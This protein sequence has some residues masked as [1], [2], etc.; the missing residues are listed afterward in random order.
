M[1]S[2]IRNISIRLRFNI[3]IAIVVAFITAMVLY[4]IITLSNIKHY[5]TY[6]QNIAELKSN[7]LNT[8]IFEQNFISGYNSDPGF[9]ST[10]ENKYL[11]KHEES[12]KKFNEYLELLKNDKLTKTLKLTEN[13]ERITQVDIVYNDLFKEIVQKIIQRGSVNSG[14]I[15]NM[16]NVSEQTLKQS[17]N[18]GQSNIIFELKQNSDNYLFS[19][20]SNH[21]KSFI[22]NF[23]KL[24]N[25]SLNSGNTN[26]DTAII[27][28]DIIVNDNTLIK[29]LNDYKQYF[30]SLVDIDKELGFTLNEGLYG[31]LRT[32]SQNI[33]PELEQLFLAINNNKSFVFVAVYNSIYIISLI[34]LLL[35]VFIILQFSFSIKKPIN[36]LQ[37]KLIPLSKG[38]IPDTVYETTGKDEMSSINN[39]INE[40][41]A[42][43]RQTTQFAITLGKGIFNTEF[44]PLSADDKLGNS[45]LEM[46]QNLNQAKID[47]EKR[48]KEDDMRKWANEGLAT[49]NDILRQSTG[50][51]QKLSDIVIRKLV[52]FLNANQAGLFIFNNSDPHDAHFDL[53]SS[54]AFGHEKK[55]H[56]KIYPGEGLVGTAAVEKETVYMTDIPQ[57]YITITSGLGGAAPRS[58]LI[59]PMKVE[60][61]V[62]GVIEIASFNEFRSY[63]I[64]FVEKVSENIAAS[65]SIA[66]INSRT[67][68]LLEQ[69]QLQAEQMAAQEQEMRRNFEE[70]QLAQEDSAR[71]E[72]EMTSIL[73]AI[74]DS[75]L[76]IE[77][78]T[79]G[80][81]TS[82]NRNL[83]DLLAIPESQIVDTLHQS[84]INPED[85]NEYLRFWLTVKEGQHVQR[86]EHILVGEKEY[87]LSVIY[88][89]ILDDTGNVVKI[90]S[91]ATDFSESKK[92]E[93]ELKKQT[94]IMSMQE[95]RMRQNLEVLHSTQD[96][97]AKKQ[98]QLEEI[99]IKSTANER[100][101]KK[102]VEKSKEQENEL[103]EK[104][105]DL[106]KLKEE[107]EEQK[108]ISGAATEY[109]FQDPEIGIKLETIEHTSIIAT[110]NLDGTLDN[111]NHNFALTF[112]YKIEEIKGKH[113]RMFI[114][115]DKKKSKDYISFWESLRKGETISGEFIRINSK[116]EDLF[117]KGKYSPVKDKE[118]NLIKI[119]E[120]LENVSKFKMLKF[121][122]TEINNFLEKSNSLLYFDEKG[123][124]LEANGV[125]AESLDYQI[126]EIIGK[127][128]K[129]FVTE[130][131]SDSIEYLH[132]WRDLSR[133]E[134]IKGV[135]EIIGKN[136]K[137]SKQKGTFS[138]IKN[139]SGSVNKVIFVGT[140]IS[141]LL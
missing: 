80:Y 46:R 74:D 22:N 32:E 89:A 103:L 102:A 1:I 121:E 78:D 131:Y 86:F 34:I 16:I 37:N 112:G 114:E 28:G 92:I 132:F 8:R 62:F 118:N 115:S 68:E 5:Q 71:R 125:I 6:K 110:Y 105:K 55:K 124:I 61:E 7:Y 45:L 138:G 120:I 123:N 2:F 97:M 128:Y 113:H 87:W 91:L 73:S 82:V 77:I 59:V 106:N 122:F 126:N 137:V 141:D 27:P 39:S 48:K 50:N 134:Q 76:V 111:A 40:L 63:E 83:L 19:R 23:M 69:S 75:S 30:T 127:N 47:E 119:I 3:L 60:D 67:A 33:E 129:D 79:K 58:L 98:A 9:F 14:I 130:E 108:F 64:E 49:F 99:N 139:I 52:H 117:F 133:G 85:E 4:F 107:L 95:E 36:I 15:G 29:N 96:E 135:F 13:I 44:Q 109:L 35:L 10:Q 38:N 101:L 56:K 104:I 81:I 26:P 18:T 11:K 42:G 57:T 21:Y 54:Y 53:T 17:Q 66:R 140:D 88:A 70:L 65:L 136:N 24:T 41:V 84:F 100:I 43:L 51:I 12:E 116:G 25:V 20:N 31:K 93:I 90:L 72:A 94:E